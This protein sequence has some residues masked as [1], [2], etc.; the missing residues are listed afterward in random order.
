MEQVGRGCGDQDG[1]GKGRATQGLSVP[2]P[3]YH[4]PL[5]Y[6]MGPLVPACTHGS[7][8][9]TVVR[10]QACLTW[11]RLV[12]PHIPPQACPLFLDPRAANS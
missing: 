5:L 8:H 10:A 6:P 7:Q 2:T 4:L 12:Y 11:A 1:W 9:S 3:V